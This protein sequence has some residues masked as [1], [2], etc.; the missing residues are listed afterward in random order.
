MTVVAVEAASRVPRLEAA[1]LIELRSLLSRSGY[2]ETHEL[3]YNGAPAPPQGAPDEPGL[4]SRLF[5]RGEALDRTDAATAIAPLDVETLVRAGLLQARQEQVGARFQIQVY[6]GLY[7]IVD[8]MAAEQPPDLVL[9]IGPSGKYLAEATIRRPVESALDL[10]C[11]CGIQ[12]L[13]MSR[14]SSR[15][16]ATDINP[17][18]LRLTQINARLNGISNVETLQGSYF[19]PVQN[20]SFDLITA[21]LPYVITPEHRLLYRDV[22]R[23]DDVPIR[24]S[25]Q[26]APNHLNEGGYA[27]FLINWIHTEREPWWEPIET[28][29]EHRN[30]DAWMLYAKSQ[31][32]AAYTNQWLLIDA[33]TRPDEY[34]AATETWRRW[35]EAHGI[36]R[37]GFGLLTLRRRTAHNNWRC[38]VLATR[39]ANEPL[40]P[41]LLHL[42]QNQD[43][44]AK[45]GSPSALLGWRL[46][47]RSLKVEWTTG[48]GFVARTTQGF[49][50]RRPIHRETARTITALDGTR[51]LDEAIRKALSPW[52]WP[53]ARIVELCSREIY[54]LANV[55][56]IEPASR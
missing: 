42:F 15:V 29:L 1:Q 45:V 10:G 30:A 46:R 33:A 36:E 9:P 11:G 51:T 16:T 6:A 48:G 23:P 44:L 31:D 25:A 35:Y 7:F 28:W 4:L 18:A 3:Q 13:L 39:M 27:H 26:A 2:A 37:I 21:N 49:L 47:P 52:S 41:H 32:A 5:A 22:G 43:E 56:M 40:G 24:E 50:I 17:R 55:G 20:A 19:E 8:F 54:D 12:A 34:A 53:K 38:F 14:H